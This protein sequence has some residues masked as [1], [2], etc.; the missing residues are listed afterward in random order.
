[1]FENCDNSH[2]AIAFATCVRMSCRVRMH[3]YTHGHWVCYVPHGTEC[4]FGMAFKPT[5]SESQAALRQPGQWHCLPTAVAVAQLGNADKGC[6]LV[7]SQASAGP[8][9]SLEPSLALPTFQR[10]CGG[11][12]MSLSSQPGIQFN[13]GC[14]K[15]DSEPSLSRLGGER[16]CCS[17]VEHHTHSNTTAGLCLS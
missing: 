10:Q 1:M 6:H 17:E 8:L 14:F 16:R 15:Q 2:C 5:P 3:E 4:M 12:A 11:L 13:S 9:Q 7:P